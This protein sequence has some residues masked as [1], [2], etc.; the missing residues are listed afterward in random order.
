VYH[1]VFANQLVGYLAEY[2]HGFESD[3]P[4]EEFNSWELRGR[5][6]EAVQLEAL[7]EFLGYFEEPAAIYIQDVNMSGLVRG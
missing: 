3:V 6:V 7:G 2:I 5:D 4:G 1:V